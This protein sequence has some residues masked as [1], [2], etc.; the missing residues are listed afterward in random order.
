MNS[1]DRRLNEDNTVHKF[2]EE[3]TR[4]SRPITGGS[5]PTTTASNRGAIKQQSCP[6]ALNIVNPTI[7]GETRNVEDY[8]VT[9]PL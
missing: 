9:G 8:S 4:S 5:S 1:D 7:R 2:V 6:F 3:R